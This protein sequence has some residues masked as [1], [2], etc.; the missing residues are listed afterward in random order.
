VHLK[1]LLSVVLALQAAGVLPAEPA[2]DLR[3]VI[4]DDAALASVEIS[5]RVD[6]QLI[7]VRGDGSVFMQSTRQQLPLLPTCK[8]KVA[9]ADIRRLLETM[10]T[11][12]FLNLPQKSYMMLNG[13]EEDWRKLQ[14]HSISIMVAA[15][16]AKRDFSA[17]EYRGEHQ[18]IPEK[19]ATIEKAIVELKSKAIPLGTHCTVA[20]PLWSEDKLVST[21]R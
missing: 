8:G 20:P 19:F 9:P 7:A 21:V 1:I 2:P 13:D 11:A 12:Q 6:G 14:L 16:S 10:L 15:G 3:H 18:E 17:G 5:Y 4:S